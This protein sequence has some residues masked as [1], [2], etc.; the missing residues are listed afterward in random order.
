MSAKGLSPQDADAIAEILCRRANE[1]ASYK[2]AHHRPM[3]NP[4]RELPGSVELALSREIDRLRDLET[5]VEEL[6]P[7]IEP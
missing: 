5:K 3:A 1:I 2:E 6:N 7:T 4:P